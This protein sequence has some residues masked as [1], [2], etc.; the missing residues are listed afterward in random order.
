MEELVSK[1][2]NISNK[3]ENY[4]TEFLK[5]KPL[6]L[7]PYGRVDRTITIVTELLLLY[8]DDLISAA[9]GTP[10]K[11]VGVRRPF[12]FQELEKETLGRIKEITKW[13]F[14]QA[15]SSFEYTSKETLFYY[16]QQFYALLIKLAKNKKKFL[17]L[18]DIMKESS[19]TGFISNENYK[20]WDGIVYVRNCIVHNNAVADKNENYEIGGVKI[21]CVKN[22]MLKGDKLFFLNMLDVTIDLYNEW[23]N[24]IFKKNKLSVI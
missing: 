12:T 1:C 6:D 7:S 17:Y 23:I 9:S 11:R 15:I 24:S 13:S 18:N 2:R 3:L 16:R 22:K 20:K 10:K 14:I 5:D 19:K 21:K 8:N 4:H